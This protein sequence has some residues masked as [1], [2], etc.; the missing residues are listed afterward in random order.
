[1]FLVHSKRQ[2]VGLQVQFWLWRQVWEA[3]CM[4]VHKARF[5]GRGDTENLDEGHTWLLSRY[6][7]AWCKTWVSRV[8]ERGFWTC[9]FQDVLKNWSIF[10]SCIASLASNGRHCMCGIPH[11]NYPG[12]VQFWTPYS[13]SQRENNFETPPWQNVFPKHLTIIY[14]ILIGPNC[15]RTIMMV[16]MQEIFSTPRENFWGIVFLIWGEKFYKEVSLHRQLP[17]LLLK[18]K[19][20]LSLRQI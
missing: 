17:H 12:P 5:W 9:F 15:A 2:D 3:S 1:M 14:A 16:Q 13:V 20:S 10:Q 19:K 6:R 11:Q 4:T 7:R 8:G 18:T